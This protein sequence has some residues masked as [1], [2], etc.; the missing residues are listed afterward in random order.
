MLLMSGLT[1]SKPN[2]IQGAGGVDFSK[3][4]ASI[5]GGPESANKKATTT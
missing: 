1:G 4:H 5:W 2:K 3:M